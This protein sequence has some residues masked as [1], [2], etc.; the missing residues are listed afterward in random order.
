M[1][2][3]AILIDG[4]YLLKRLST[5]RPDVD[6]TDPAAVARSVGELVEGHLNLLNEVYRAPNAL[7]LRYRIF[8]YYARPYG[9]RAHSPVDRRLIDYARTNQALFR[10]SPPL[11]ACS[12]VVPGLALSR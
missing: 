2:K 5:V 9:N 12:P 6:A 4:A 8:Y 10:R 11:P 7:Q 1:T 3:A